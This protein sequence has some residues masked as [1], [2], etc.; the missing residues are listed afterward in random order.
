VKRLRRFIGDFLFFCGC[1]A[2]SRAAFIVK[3]SE[4]RIYTGKCRVS[5]TGAVEK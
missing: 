5:L 4:A 3:D 2:F 1:A